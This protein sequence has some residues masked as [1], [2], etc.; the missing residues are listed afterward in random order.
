MKIKKLLLLI[1]VLI[2]A[3]FSC[4]NSFAQLSPLSDKE[5]EKVRSK[6]SS[7]GSYSQYGKT[8]PFE[9]PIA[10][11]HK[12]NDDCKKAGNEMGEAL[13]MFGRAEREMKSAG[14]E[15]GPCTIV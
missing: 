10:Q 5:L 9:S 14:I 12:W 15:P 2:C 6:A 11:I 8:V 13:G 1:C 4:P 7:S 3:V